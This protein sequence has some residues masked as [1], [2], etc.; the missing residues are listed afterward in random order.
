[1]KNLKV[2][3][4]VDINEFIWDKNEGLFIFDGVFVLLFWDFVI[5]FFFKIIE[6]V[7]GSDVFII[8]FEVIGFCM[9][10]LVSNYY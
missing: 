1:M 4:K 5:E 8:V 10:Y 9:G 6:E 2:S 3:V 7:L